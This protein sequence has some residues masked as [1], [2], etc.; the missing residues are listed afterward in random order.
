MIVV[1]LGGLG[2]TLAPAGDPAARLKSQN[3]LKII[4]LAMHEYADRNRGAFPQHAIYSKD[5]KTPL[6]SWR[7]A[8]LPYLGEKKLYDEFKLDEP[9]DSPHNKK[10]I[11]RMPKEY[12]MPAGKK[13]PGETYYQVFTGPKTM[14]DGTKVMKITT[15]IAGT[16]NTVLVAEAKNPV[17]WTKPADLTLPADKGKLP[18]LGGQFPNGFHV[19]MCDGS[20]RMLPLNIDPARLRSILDPRGGQ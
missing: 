9:W 3:N 1:L 12:E 16:S 2:A 6:L 14:F 8:I 10:L 7:V 5:G 20:V 18:A 15:I 11:E 19:L 17:T 13:A 4:G